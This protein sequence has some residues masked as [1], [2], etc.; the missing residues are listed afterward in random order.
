[1]KFL[2]KSIVVLMLNLIVANAQSFGQSLPVAKLQGLYNVQGIIELAVVAESPFYVGANVFVL[3][4]GDVAFDR[5]HQTDIDQKGSLRFIM[6]KEEYSLLQNG[7]AVFLSYGNLFDE[8]LPI[9]ERNRIA[10]ESPDLCQ[11]LGNFS[12]EKFKK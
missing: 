7:A 10:N 4:I 8:Q 6:S 1:M 2:L 11:Y 3:H 9:A 12:K 5:Y